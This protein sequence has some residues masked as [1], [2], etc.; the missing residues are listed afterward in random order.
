[1]KNEIRAEQPPSDRA[2]APP[3]DRRSLAEPLSVELLLC[4]ACGDCG[5]PA[6]TNRPYSFC[7]QC[8]WSS[9]EGEERTSKPE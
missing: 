5:V 4:P 3:F 9:H 1:M 8:G 7:L 6:I 2:T